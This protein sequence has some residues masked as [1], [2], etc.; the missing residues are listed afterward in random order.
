[1][2]LGAQNTAVE[3]GLIYLTGL[4]LVSVI[5]L[6]SEARKI[7]ISNQGAFLALPKLLQVLTNDT[8]VSPKH[9]HKRAKKESMG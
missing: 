6:T 9:L 5:F 3:K 7:S 4:I 2:V 8:D 1:M